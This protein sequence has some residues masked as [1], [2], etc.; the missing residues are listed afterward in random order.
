MKTKLLVILGIL[1][2]SLTTVLADGDGSCWGMGGMMG[3]SFGMGG[4]FF[5]WAFSLLIVVALVLLI[6]WL[7]K[8]IQ[9]K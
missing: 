4:M 2:I 5:G 1:V 9:K 8:Q 3:G 6:V 7:I